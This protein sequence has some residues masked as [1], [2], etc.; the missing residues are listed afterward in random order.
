DNKVFS[1]FFKAESWTAW[2]VFLAALF[3]LPLTYDQLQLYK[4][5]TGRS[6]APTKPLSEAWLVVGRRGRK[7]SGLAAI[8]TTLAGFRDCRPSLAAGEIATIMLLAKD[9]AQARSIKRYIS[10]LL[11]EAPM[12]A[13]MIEDE[14][15]ESIRLRNRINIE[16]HA[17]SYRSTR[18]YTIVAALLDEVA[19]WESDETSAEPDV[20]IINAIKPGMATIP[21][22]VLLCASSPHARRGALWEAHCKHFG[23][24]GDPVLVWQ[25][26]TRTMNPAVPQS[27]IDAHMAEDPARAR[28]EYFAQF[29]TDVETFISREVVDAAIV[30]GR[31]ELPRIAGVHYTGFVD[32]SGGSSDSMTLAIA[33]VED[34]AGIKRAVVDLIREVKPPFSPDAVV[35]EFASLLKAYGVDAVRGDRYGGTWPRERFCVHGVDYQP[36]GKATSDIYLELLPVLNSSRAELLD[37]PRLITQITQLERHAG[38]GKDRIQHPPGGHDD[39]V[40]AVAG[41]IVTALNAASQ[42]VVSVAM[43]VVV[44]GAPRY[45]AGG[46]SLGYA[47]AVV[48]PTPAALRPPTDEPRPTSPDAQREAKRQAINNDR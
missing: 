8:A 37:H 43:P 32:P 42:D 18:G 44:G 25:A 23:Q 26:A 21:R 6:I 35:R 12:L 3:G 33:H 39:V 45:V 46:S 28:A 30:P 40:N 19:F 1:R 11:R 7:S 16:I 47:D 24:D 29:R 13:P 2:R 5:C 22:A 31:H 15:A 36:A 4:Q 48:M 14:T 17:A 9:G 34:D 27:H 20:E 10:G 38:S 41:A